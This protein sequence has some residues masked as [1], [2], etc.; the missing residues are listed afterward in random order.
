MGRWVRRRL[1]STIHNL[2]YDEAMALDRETRYGG[3]AHC[4]EVLIATGKGWRVEQRRGWSHG[5]RYQGCR[6]IGSWQASHT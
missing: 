1:L 5:T 4:T 6:W 2:I 3:G